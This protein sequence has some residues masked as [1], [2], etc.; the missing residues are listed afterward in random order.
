M[1]RVRHSTA[2]LALAVLATG[3]LAGAVTAASDP[4]TSA[5]TFVPPTAP[6]PPSSTTGTVPRRPLPPMPPSA[7]GPTGPAVSPTAPTTP[8]TPAART[9]TPVTVLG[10]KATNEDKPFIAP[11]LQ[12]IAKELARS[13]FNSFR[14]TTSDAKIVPA[15]GETLVPMDEG[16]SMRIRVEKD[17]GDAVTMT[18]SWQRTDIMP[19]GGTQTRLLQRMQIVL[20]KGRYFLSGGWKLKDGALWAA[21]SAQ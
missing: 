9:V 6:A 21:V 16:Y 18:V 4:S 1:S 19:D 14:V 15:G 10:I 2:I 11:A 7:I 17:A 20:R 8:T 3:I 12:P 5:P 13:S